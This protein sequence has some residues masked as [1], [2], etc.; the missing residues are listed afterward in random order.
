MNLFATVLTYPAPSAN[1]R[2]ESELN[3]TVIQKVTEGRFDYAIISPEAMRN[4]LRE[5]L[6]AYGLPCNR[7]RLHD[8]EQLAVTF[9][10]YPNPVK[11]VDDFFFGY[12]VAA[13][14]KDRKAIREEVKRD[15]FTFK[16]DSILRMNL[17][18]AL[19]P[20]R[21]N[22]VFTQSPLAAEGSK[23]K[24]A[25]TSALLHRE[26]VVS[27]FQYPLA[28]NLDDCEC[29]DK[30][31]THQTP[32]EGEKTTCKRHWTRKLLQAIGELN[33]V[34]GNHA[35]SYYEM[36]PASIVL[37]LTNSL[38]AGYATYGFKPDGSFPEVI[39][40]ILHDPPDYAGSE[41]YLGGKLVKDMPA[42]RQQ[43]LR[44]RGV[45]LERDPRKVLSIVADKALGGSPS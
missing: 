22:A 35:R 18:K 40:G 45:I 36:A 31:C 14:S 7:S 28:L 30:N 17:A 15:D 26:T 21:H 32:K 8:E 25:P 23:Y 4:A 16:R 10:D 11:Y 38:V 27:A 12:L 19:E 9:R 20:Y 39:D 42:D 29:K 41:F 5:I 43:K 13:G 44:E 34:A 2:G 37:R 33:E 6:A 3:R 1:Y 24:N